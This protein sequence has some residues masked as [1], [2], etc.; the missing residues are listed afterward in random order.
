MPH[1]AGL[2]DLEKA[3]NNHTN[4]KNVSTK[5]QVKMAKFVLK[6]NNFE[7]NGKVKQQI[8]GTATGTKFPLLRPVY[9]WTKWK[10]FCLR[11]GK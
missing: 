8:L 4:N 9:L 3:L 5:D 6:N 7:F 1:E 2:K 10:L 11:H